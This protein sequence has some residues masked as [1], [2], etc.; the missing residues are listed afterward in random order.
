MVDDAHLLD[1]TSA[2]FI[3]QLVL[4]LTGFV[5][6][7]IR[8][9]AVLPAAIAEVLDIGGISRIELGP[10]S[11]PE[12]AMAAR[13]ML[14][15]PVGH[16][17]AAE[18][19][20]L[21][22]GNPRHLYWLIQDALSGGAISQVDGIWQLAGPI[23]PGEG[24]K[25]TFVDIFSSLDKE[26][27]RTLEL[28]AVASPVP[29]ARLEQLV[30]AASLDR[31]EEAGLIIVDPACPRSTTTVKSPLL[32]QVLSAQIPVARRRYFGR[33]LTGAL[34]H[35]EDERVHS[36]SA[37]WRLD[38]GDVDGP[39]V[40]VAG[41][42]RA[43]DVGDYDAAERYARKAIDAGESVSG[44]LVLADALSARGNHDK[45]DRVL[46]TAASHAVD[47]A[48]IAQTAL[49]RMRL[50]LHRYHER[51]EAVQLGQEALARIT[52][53]DW[54]DELAAELALQT[55]LAGDYRAA[56]EIGARVVSRADARDRATV[57]A[58]M[59]A[60]QG[61]VMLGRLEDVIPAVDR[62][63]ECAAR[64]G[65]EM[66]DAE[67]LLTVARF[68]AELFLGRFE[69]AAETAQSGFRGAL[70]ARRP[71]L[72]GLW[73]ACVAAAAMFRGDI[74]GATEA[75]CDATGLLSLIDPWQSLP[76]TQCWHALAE[77]QRGSLQKAE[78]ILGKVEGE[79]LR[80]EFR[81]N[82]LKRRVRAWMKAQ[83]GDATGAVQDARTAGVQLADNSHVVWG[84][85]AL[86]DAARFG[87]PEGVVD[88]LGELA[89]GVDGKLVDCMARHARALADQDPTSLDLV[90]SQ[91][92]A[93]GALT[94][95]AEAAAQA[96]RLYER[97][98]DRGSA[99]R[100]SMRSSMLAGSVTGSDTPA[101]REPAR[102]LTSREEEIA[103]LAATGLPSRAIASRLGISGRTVDNHLGSV[104]VKLAVGSRSELAAVIS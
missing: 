61:Q 80:D 84:C 34:D 41:A 75:Y 14:G 26:E 81:V 49:A 38:S 88:L 64:L 7:S 32:A 36:I 95:A 69:T 51:D 91:L 68:Q 53:I 6:L 3:H 93:I 62:G 56:L 29:L 66:P 17:A 74:V 79:H 28:V 98:G 20:R 23:Q 9:D 85:L 13:S 97:D 15:A 89:S 96:A 90:S 37:Q 101:L 87:R 57:S 54:Q 8:R 94:M 22:G 35:S 2:T 83:M 73:G 70:E 63:L 33:L 31:I 99:A 50:R 59:V 45:A 76:V 12:T 78:Q 82:A 103:R 48:G 46:A 67:S 4:R 24:V 92:A 16:L 65:N 77:A 11:E 104:Y 42:R 1:E 27:I 19:S 58:L 71:P 86:H 102:F 39:E 44:A 72:V 30:S 10:L 40:W 43:L 21:S 60:T 52:S 18:L 47:D 100:A 25:R 5:V 55:G